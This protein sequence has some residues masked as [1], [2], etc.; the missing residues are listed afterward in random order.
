MKCTTGLP[1]SSEFRT[2]SAELLRTATSVSH[3]TVG[4]HGNQ[5]A[6]PVMA[7]RPT[8]GRSPKIAHDAQFCSPNRCRT[9]MGSGTLPLVKY[10][11]A[12]LCMRQ[13]PPDVV[14]VAACVPAAQTMQIKEEGVALKH[15]AH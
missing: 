2:E 14:S 8:A 4:T 7:A 9:G 3:S 15:R 5:S 11:A 1:S 6:S 13:P 10:N 12:L